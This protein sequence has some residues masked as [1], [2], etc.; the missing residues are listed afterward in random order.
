MQR[1]PSN[2]PFQMLM[3]PQNQ[4]NTISDEEK[5]RLV[6]T[7]VGEVRLGNQKPGRLRPLNRAEIG[8]LYAAVGL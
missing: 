7:A 8:S 3:A 2:N 5:Q 1:T 6:R 4:Q